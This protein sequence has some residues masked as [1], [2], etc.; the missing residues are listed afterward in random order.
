MLKRFIRSGKCIR[1][2]RWLRNYKEIST[3]EEF[4]GLEDANEDV[5]HL[6]FGKLRIVLV[7][8]LDKVL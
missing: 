2:L 5:D 1:W 6:V 8:V 7:P 4:V 3:C